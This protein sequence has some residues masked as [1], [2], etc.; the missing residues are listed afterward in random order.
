M[1]S[2]GTVIKVAGVACV[3]LFAL[4]ASGADITWTGGGLQNNQW[5]TGANWSSGNMPAASDVAIFNEVGGAV[6]ITADATIRAVRVE[7]TADVTLDIANGSV[8][9]ISNA[10][11]VGIHAETANLTFNGPGLL[12]LTRNNTTDFLDCGVFPD[13]TVT[14][15]AKIIGSPNGTPVGI[16]MYLATPAGGTFGGTFVLTA[17]DNDLALYPRIYN[18]VLSV[19]QLANAG[20]PSCIGTDAILH[21]CNGG[22]LRYTGAGDST[23]RALQLAGGTATFG[24]GGGI[25]QAGTGIL[26]WAGS[27]YNSNN[28]TQTLTLFGDSASE[29]HVTGAIYNN[30]GSLG[31]RKDGSGTWA[32]SG[33]NA[34]TGPIAIDAG[35]LVLDATNAVG[36]AAAITMASGTTLRVNRSAADG[37]T[38]T[39]PAMS[40][41]GHVS[42]II[43]NAPTASTVTIGGL[44]GNFAIT[45]P[46]AGSPAN[47]I[48]VS[49]LP[50]GA[51]GPWLTLNGGPAQYDPANG[52]APTTSLTPD[53]L[54]TKGNPLPSG[55]AAIQAA[56]SAVGTGLDIWLPSPLTTLYSLTLTAPGDAAVDTAGK[57]LMATE[58][59]NASAAHALTIGLLPQDGTLLPP[60]A[61]NPA[62]PAP[63]IPDSTAIS[64]LHPVIWYDPSEAANVTVA[65]GK[66]V[67]LKNKGDLGAT[68][69]AVVPA[70][71]IGFNYATGAESHAALPMLQKQTQDAVGLASA[72][73]TGITDAAHRTLIAVQ[74]RPAANVQCVVSMGLPD[75]DLA[76]SMY[77]G[78]DDNTARFS[79]WFNDIDIKVAQPIATPTVMT[80]ISGV[81]GIAGNAQGFMDYT[82]SALSVL[83]L[84]TPDTPLWLGYNKLNGGGPRSQIGEVLL[85]NRALTPPEYTAVIDYLT[86]K[87]K[88]PK[89]APAPAQ[90]ATLTLRSDSPAAPLIINA[91]ITPQEESAVSLLKAGPGNVTLA[92]G[93]PLAAPVLIDGGTLTLATPTAALDTLSG[94]ISGSGKLVK[95]G[96]GILALPPATANQYLGGTDILGGTLSIANSLSLGTGD[97]TIAGSGALDIGGATAN[98]TVTLRN[99][100]F[101]A[102]AG[103]DGSGAIVH[104]GSMQQMNIFWDTAITLTGHTTIGGASAR[105]WDIARNTGAVLDLNGFTLTKKGPANVHCSGSPSITN[106]PA[107]TALD[108][109]EGTFGIEGAIAMEPNDALRNINIGPAG[110]LGIYNLATR[111]DWT[112]TTGDGSTIWVYGG[113]LTTN[114][115]VLPG[116]IL[117]DGT[118]HLTANGA[119]N[120]TLA[121]AISG[122]GGITLSGGMDAM[123]LLANP[124]NTFTGPV[125]VTNALLGLLYPT[126]LPGFDLNKLSLAQ[127]GSAVRIFMGHPGGWTGADAKTLAES[128]LFNAAA[129]DHQILQVSVGDGD[130]ASLP[131]FGSAF[132]GSIGKFGRGALS[133]DE[134]TTLRWSLRTYAGLV[135][136]TNDATFNIS[137]NVLSIGDTLRV[138]DAT[139]GPAYAL[140]GGNA[141]LTGT[142]LGYGVGTGEGIFIGPHGRS[143]VMDITGNA[144]VHGKISIGGNSAGDTNGV[145]AVYQSGGTVT[146]TCGAGNDGRMGRYGLGYYQLDGG[147]SV[148]KGYIDF[149]GNVHPNSIGILRQT[150]GTFTF[151]GSRYTA[152]SPNVGESYGGLISVSRGGTGV[153]HL[154]GGTF[155]HYGALGILANGAAAGTGIVTV[156][157]TANMAIDRQIAFGD[158]ANA[159]ALL[160]LKGGKLTATH[161]QRANRANTCAAVNFNGGTL[162]ITNNTG[163]HNLFARDTGADAM[164]AFVYAGGARI[165]LGQG[166]TRAIDIP[167]Q[168]PKGAGI[169][170]IDVNNPGAGYIAPPHVTITGGGGTNATAIARI[171]RAKGTLTGIEITNPG[172]GYT[173]NPTVI[174]TAGGYTTPAT[175]TAPAT[176]KDNGTGGLTKAGPGTLILSAASTYLGPT[177]VEAGTLTLTHPQAIPPHSEIIIGDGTLDLGGNT[178]T[179]ISVTIEGTGGIVNGNVITAAA[180]K[181]GPGTATWGAGIRFAL[182]PGIPGLWEGRLPNG[183]TAGINTADPAPRTG[184]ELTTTAANGYGGSSATLNGKH[185]PDY[186]TYVYSGYIWNN[187]GEPATWTF[188]KSFDDTVW[189]KINDA[190]EYAFNTHNVIT[191]HQVHL[192]PGPNKFDIRFGQG[193]GSVG[194]MSQGWW[195]SSAMP[196]GIDFEGRNADT[197]A[198]Y[199][200]LLDPGDGTLFT[201]TAD[202]PDTAI[203][204]EDGTLALLPTLTEDAIDALAPAIWYD[205][206]D[207]TT[208][209]T[210][211]SGRVTGLRNKGRFSATHNAIVRNG[212]TGPNLV[213]GDASHAAL[214]MLQKQ[215]AANVGL[216]SAASTGISGNDPRT[217]IAVQSNAANTDP[218]SCVVSLGNASNNQAFSMYLGFSATASRFATWSGDIDIT[219]PHP[220]A[221]P[222]VMTFISGVGGTR[223]NTQA[224]IDRIPSPVTERPAMATAD[225]P[226]WLGRN[227][228]SNGAL[229]SQIGEVLLFTRAIT[230]AERA[231]IQAYL[232]A[233][234]VKGNLPAAGFDGTAINVADGATLDL[235]GQPCAGLTIT[236][237]GQAINGTSASGLILSPAGDT[238]TG[239]LSVDGLTA[240]DGV[241]YHLTIHDPAHDVINLTGAIDLT[242]LTIAPSDVASETPAAAKYIIATATVGFTGAKPALDGF[243][244]NYTTLRKGSELWLTTI[245]GTVLILR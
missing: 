136:F 149:G 50:T 40:S 27:I 129:K 76:F 218:N 79:P 180:A 151:N 143:G 229:N 99:R 60:F 139:E 181:T 62:P 26:T 80:F 123:N 210:D 41:A 137:T 109:Q 204:V 70:G 207:A 7:G 73:D 46:N 226:L 189:M 156:D 75:R 55:G 119:F 15:N 17:E 89:P 150:G 206:S 141:V 61:L 69:D 2:I 174:L 127:N 203:R 154:E 121:G 183:G 184:I 71:F 126:S 145:G 233:K 107:G 48:L 102:G 176:R 167:L 120:K 29:A 45:A 164:S 31:I 209:T 122:N 128:G 91:A 219:A 114:Q 4:G 101:A 178:I 175:V 168:H 199:A 111:P 98:D 117:L 124:A 8:F 5:S 144:L 213:T 146:N 87:W 3:F 85:F 57:T 21:V 78:Y 157:G 179:N 198:N 134:D 182:V 227:N 95:D 53:T 104:N 34:F 54:D 32:L 68:H 105:R 162:S 212:F 39:L 193:T 223:N 30:Q 187:T 108:I 131:A 86:L 37:F 152:P 118:L 171:D 196:V 110:C 116:A 155:T 20:R 16:D 113:N 9:T 216:Q 160:N 97:V 103:P 186:S 10:G 228:L 132:S 153:L 93:A 236:G 22:T 63:A 115:N 235:S 165:E 77:L 130:S 237:N 24:Y 35:T 172:Y 140:I 232:T 28:S 133:F 6:A 166:V 65:F 51:V 220:L 217:L 66:A 214:P 36:A 200:P 94:I 18:H 225:T 83:P 84:K 67:G 90:A 142:D 192:N 92:G 11:S 230:D 205:P 100:I 25:E 19:H 241:T 208:R 106:A 211:G 221:T 231:R 191:K 12:A 38:T 234:W 13:Y 194:A 33:I 245:G 224:F 158:C 215:D 240:L 43:T 177:R 47:R 202:A 14:I 169:S 190:Q 161:F 58:V 59:A 138:G 96:P 42:L 170:A 222:A 173:S 135:C 72:A 201:L 64:N 23:D 44:Y 148:I 197:F 242:G 185:W 49:G 112:L 74:S 159:T 56:I 52:L 243:P 188:A 1:K 81:G 82:P 195:T 147:E 163:S 239:T 244:A 125:A 238:A 88:Q